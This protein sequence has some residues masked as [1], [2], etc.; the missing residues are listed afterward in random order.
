MFDLQKDRKHQE[1][2]GYSLSFFA[3]PITKGGN[4]YGMRP[5]SRSVNT[6]TINGVRIGHKLSKTSDI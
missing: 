2:E 1:E 4:E 5:L 3:S 6:E